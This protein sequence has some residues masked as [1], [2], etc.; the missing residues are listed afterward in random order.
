MP[1]GV[2]GKTVIE[3]QRCHIEAKIG[4][5]LHIGMTT[6]NVGAA[7]GVSNIAGGEQQNAARTDVRRAGRELGLSHRPDQR[8]RLLLGEDFGDM[9][10]LCFG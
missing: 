8:R 7:P 6:K 2:F 1:P 4:G 10:D 9:F 5:T 3:R